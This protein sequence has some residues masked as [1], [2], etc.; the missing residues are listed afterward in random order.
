MSRKELNDQL[1]VSTVAAAVEGVYMLSV[2][3]PFDIAS[4]SV[5]LSS[6]YSLL[7]LKSSLISSP[8]HWSPSPF[9]LSWGSDLSACP[10]HPWLGLCPWETDL[11]TMS[12][13]L[14]AHPQV[15]WHVPSPLP[16]CP[17]AKL[18]TDSKPYLDTTLYHSEDENQKVR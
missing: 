3:H 11:G 15:F 13:P 6:S 8:P 10:S 18:G 16:S 2:C 5:S 1:M 4:T 9:H 7:I 17:T 12:Q 14:C